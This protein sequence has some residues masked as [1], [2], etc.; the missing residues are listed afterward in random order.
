M[1]HARKVVLIVAFAA[2]IGSAVYLLRKP[3]HETP[4]AEVQAETATPAQAPADART[5]SP[6]PT[7]AKAAE[8]VPVSA[9]SSSHPFEFIRSLAKSAYDGDGR[10]QYLI[11]R[12]LDKCEMTLSLLRKSDVDPETQIWN[13]PESGWSQVMK[14]RAIAELRRCRRLLKEDPFA[15]LPPRKGGYTFQYWMAKS[16]ESGYPLAVVEKSLGDWGS[17]SEGGTNGKTASAESLDKLAAATSTGDPEIALT[18]GFRQTM[19]ESP[20][21]KTAASAWM[22][23]AC[24]MGADCSA[25]SKAVPF[26]MCYD[27]SYPN[28]D[29]DGTVELMISMSMS[30]ADYGAAYSQSQ[31]VE[32]VLRSRDPDAIRKLLEQLF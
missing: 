20:A 32:A 3:P 8:T 17:Q 16:V 12:E 27:P 11:S 25:N 19:Y 7:A 13:F 14:E 4:A 21:R 10:A 22:L 26:W 15:D 30:A 18:I 29:I 23:A 1:R 24:R 2:I 6:L 31:H 9:G 28:C 5:T